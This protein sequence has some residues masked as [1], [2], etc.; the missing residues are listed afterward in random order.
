MNGWKQCLIGIAAFVVAA[1]AFAQQAPQAPQTPQAPPFFGDWDVQMAKVEAEMARAQAELAKAGAFTGTFDLAGLQSKM[2]AAFDRS[3]DRSGM[4]FQLKNSRTGK[5]DADYDNGTRAL[6]DRRYE[7]AVRRFDAVIDSKSPRADGAL[8]W[9][10]YA[11]NRLGRRDEAIAAL[12]VLRRD[13]PNSRWL[14][15]A[16]ALEAEVKQ[17]S[18]QAVSAAQETNEDLKLMAINSLMSA[19]PVSAMP[20]LE[21][22]LKGSSTPKVKDRAMFV[23]TQNQSPRAQQI[24]AQYAKGAGNPDLQ[25]RAIRYIGMSGTNDARQQLTSIYSGSNDSGVKRQVIQSLMVSNGR[26]SL[27]TLAKGEKD[28]ELRAEAIRQLGAM[29]AADQLSQLYGSETSTENKVRIVRSLFVAGASD[30]LLDL[31][32][33]EKDPRVRGEA[34]RNLA[35]SLATSTET[36]ERLYTSD[37][38]PKTKKELVNGLFARGDAKTL[39]D[40]ARKETGPTMKKYI[41]ERLAMM[42]SKEATDY[43]MELLK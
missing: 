20:L 27:F 6:D 1:P 17:G 14:T 40:L 4:L 35:L 8:Y 12:A 30:K 31:A 37:G 5:S 42:H 2:A 33:N 43:M 22:L 3:G 41:V 11:L 10:A 34:I 28:D 21:G 9:K 7:D 13:Y 15:D 32:Q 38:D 23:L 29:R 18:G 19:D 25:M 39:I 16:Q 24:L 26:D 36:L